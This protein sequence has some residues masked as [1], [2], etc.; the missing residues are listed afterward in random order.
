[1]FL[2]ERT[3]LLELPY[4]LELPSLLV[5]SLSLLDLLSPATHQFLPEPLSLLELSS[6]LEP[7]FKTSLMV[8]S[9]FQL[10]LLDGLRLPPSLLVGFL[11]HSHLLPLFLM[12][13]QF[14]QLVFPLELYSLL[15]LPFLLV[16]LSLL[17]LPYLLVPFSHQV[18]LF[19]L[20]PLSLLELS[21]PLELS[22]CKYLLV[23]NLVNNFLLVGLL[24]FLLFLVKFLLR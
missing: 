2:K 19:L 10:F 7:L 23:G 17:A 20:E 4:L 8:P 16:L 9:L 5:P 15:E 1:V 14:L 21:S 18:L 11:D 22:S 3:S 6:L 24:T 12:V 13:P